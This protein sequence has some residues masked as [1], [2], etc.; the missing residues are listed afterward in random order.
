ML[1][2][3]RGWLAASMG[4][5]FLVLATVMAGPASA[6]DPPFDCTN[7][8]GGTSSLCKQTR[9]LGLVG[10]VVVAC[11][12]LALMFALRWYM[13]RRRA[14]ANRAA[15]ARRGWRRWLRRRRADRY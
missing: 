4:I 3:T 8:N 15:R 12:V 7:T 2:R 11:V 9:E 5:A 10:W 6:D 13:A 14:R 1:G